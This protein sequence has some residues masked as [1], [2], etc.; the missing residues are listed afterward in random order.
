MGKSQSKPNRFFNDEEIKKIA[1][2]YNK[3]G[4][5]AV[6]PL[7]KEKCDNLDNEKVSIA[8]T[9]EAGVGKSSFVNAMRGL[10]PNDEGAAKVGS[11]QKTSKPTPYQ[12]PTLPSV[13]LWDLP[14]IG[15]G[16]YST[17]EY[18]DK[19]NFKSYDLFILITGERFK[20]NDAKLAKEIKKMGKE[21]YFVCSKIDTV[22]KNLSKRGQHDR[23][24]E[25]LDKI[26]SYYKNSLEESG[27]PTSQVFLV[28]SRYPHR[29]DFMKFCGC[30]AS[31][32]PE[33]KNNVFVLSLPNLNEAVIEKK[34]K[35]LKGKIALAATVSAG[36][37]AI[38]IPGVSIACDIGILVATLLHMQRY[39]GLDD[40][41]LCRLACR[42]NK[43]VQELKAEVTS[44]FVLNITPSSVIKLLTSTVS[45]AVMI[46]DDALLLIPVI[47]SIIGATVSFIATSFLLN[48]ALDDFAESALKVLRK[49]IEANSEQEATENINLEL[50]VAKIQPKLSSPFTDN[51]L[52]DIITEI[53]HVLDQR[54]FHI[55]VTGESGKGKSAFI[56]AVCGLKPGDPEA[57]EEGF[58]EQIIK[59]KKYKHPSL[60]SVS[61]WDLPGAGTP[62][63][64]IAKYFK[65]VKFTKYHFT[66][67]M[68]GNRFT[69]NDTFIVKTLGNLKHDFYVVRSKMDNE[70]DEHEQND[71]QNS[72]KFEKIKDYYISL[73]KENGVDSPHVFLVSSHC[74]NDFDFRKLCQDLKLKVAE[75]KK[76]LC[77]CE[78]SKIAKPLVQNKKTKLK[79]TI[80]QLI[81]YATDEGKTFIPGTNCAYNSDAVVEILLF[82]R[83]YMGLDDESINQLAGK[84]GKSVVDLKSEVSDPFVLFINPTSVQN[85]FTSST[86]VILY[87]LQS[88]LKPVS[89][90]PQ[91]SEII[92]KLLESMIDVFAESAMS[93]AKKAA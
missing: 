2:V 43:P 47:G 36:L 64:E 59:P 73:L 44:P 26:K 88:L 77:P 82:Y 90:V 61:L 25:E 58:T 15:T 85:I 48:S 83:W 27:L 37:G 9:G 6:F 17:R 42:V 4:L 3:D 87:N 76:D 74:T 93:V 70:E 31:E 21:F 60:P 81:S 49:V 51:G 86:S 92:S 12:H 19:V 79:G 69:E 71:H 75:K 32:L 78:I 33:K 23:L 24:E 8:V 45:G 18:L 1:Q 84:V 16:K 91:S 35:I 65:K 14:G 68:V 50:V 29:Y 89:S 72:D 52:E 80:S 53:Q 54:E 63:F 46:A 11:T 34:K 67:V 56:N 10:G 66:V 38:P 57:A 39:L 40:E 20:E 62:K 7:I 28:S 41:S 5:D 13:C 22:E 55:A 30:L